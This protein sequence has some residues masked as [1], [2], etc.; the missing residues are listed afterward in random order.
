MGYPRIDLHTWP[1]NL[2]AVPLYKKCGFMWEKTTRGTH[3][4]NIIP[5]LTDSTLF[6]DFFAEVDWYSHNSREIKVEP[7]EQKKGDLDFFIYRWD[8]NE[9]FLE[10]EVNKKGRGI[11]AV[12]TQD[13]SIR[14][15]IQNPVCV[16]GSSNDFTIEIVNNK[17]Q[18]LDIEID[19]I[20]V[21]SI[22]CELR[23]TQLS[24]PLFNLFKF[25]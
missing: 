6:R 19:S 16:I 9:K 13:Y 24:R 12:K 3:L 11:H 4:F 18:P 5:G 25:V 2:S 20:S 17:S 14:I 21:D 23:C 10:L 7:D 8:K 15:N 1:G 22:S